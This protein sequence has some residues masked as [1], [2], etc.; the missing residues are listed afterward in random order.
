MLPS[1]WVVSTK[2]DATLGCAKAV[3]LGKAEGGVWR[4]VIAGQEQACIAWSGTRLGRRADD[5][6]G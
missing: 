5:P 6:A 3:C 4:R 2:P 1:S